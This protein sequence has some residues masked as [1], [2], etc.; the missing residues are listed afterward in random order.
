[1]KL[2]AGEFGQ[3]RGLV[4][5]LCGLAL[6]E[7]KAYLVRHRLAP[8]ARAAGCPS[9]AAFLDK[10][11]GPEGAALREPIVEAIT[12]KET[13]FFRDRHP[14]EAFRRVLLPRLGTLI[15]RRRAARQTA[16]ARVW[17]VG[18]STGQEA[19]SLAMLIDDFLRT[20]GG[21]DL[22]PQ[23]FAI[24]ATDISAQVLETAR[25]G[26]YDDRDVARGV[27]LAW[28]ERYFRREDR[29]WVIDARLRGMVEFRKVNLMDNFSGLG[30]AEVIFCRNV[31]IYFDEATRRRIC[32]RFAEMLTPDGVLVL[33]AV[34]NLYGLSARFLSEHIGPTL[35][36]RKV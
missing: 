16:P 7:E 25:A 29:A 17:S 21:P 28:Q 23:D 5:R 22:R 20:E 27:K 6:T 3:L 11:A 18:V 30:P 8:V 12:T 1:V 9:F 2:S 13:S 19:Y 24:L 4:H 26:R 33:G 35:V 10:L 34:E 32:D 31:L 14:F 36:Y 15:R